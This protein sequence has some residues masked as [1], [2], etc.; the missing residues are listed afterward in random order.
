MNTVSINDQFERL[1]LL[2][3][4]LNYS[5][6]NTESL[7]IHL[8][9]GLG[10]MDKD[11]A[12]IVFLTLNTS[13]ARIDLVDRFAKMDRTPAKERADVLKLTK[14]MIPISGLR[15]RYN[16]ALYSFD[17]DSGDA[18]AIQM[19][20]AERKGKLKIGEQ[21]ALDSVALEEIEGTLES[22]SSLNQRI[23][24]LIKKRGYPV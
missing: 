22:L 14:E 6:T 19:R 1:L 15:N 20:I 3:G 13:R 10:R 12:I 2:V 21:H 8:I 16:H 11:T 7:L 23:W 5:W 4:K 17:A 24:Q 18:T 9:A